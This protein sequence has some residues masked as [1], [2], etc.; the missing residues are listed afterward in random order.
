MEHKNA[1]SVT[2]LDLYNGFVWI[3]KDGRA[4]SMYYG[5]KILWN[6]V[7]GVEE[8]DKWHQYTRVCYAMLTTTYTKDEL[9]DMDV[10]EVKISVQPGGKV[11]PFLIKVAY[12]GTKHPVI[13]KLLKHY[14]GTRSYAN[15]NGKNKSGGLGRSDTGDA[16][17]VP[18]SDHRQGPQMDNIQD[19]V[20]TGG[21]R[22][23]K[24]GRPN[25]G[26]S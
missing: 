17:Q 3:E 18:S 1:G 11:K 24:P 5:E 4:A 12:S 20:R 7:T 15:K 13:G 6:V 21:Q 14:E 26:I 8:C 16:L 25:V 10:P 23:R 19:S 22:R 2:D 9:E